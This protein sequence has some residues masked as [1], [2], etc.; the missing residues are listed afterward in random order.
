MPA[1][2]LYHDLGVERVLR[3]AVGA[4]QAADADFTLRPMCAVPLY[5]QVSP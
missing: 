5:R 1:A 4:I 2:I 3:L